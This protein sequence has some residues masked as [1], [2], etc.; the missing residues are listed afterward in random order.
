[1]A[2]FQSA[3]GAKTFSSLTDLVALRRPAPETPLKD[4]LKPQIYLYVPN[5]KVLIEHYSF[6]ARKQQSGVSSR[7]C[8]RTKRVSY[9]M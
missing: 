7:I 3:V 2:V 6:R 5:K 8:G 4:I 9:L 1:M